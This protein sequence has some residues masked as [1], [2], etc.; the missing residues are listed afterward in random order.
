VIQPEGEHHESIEIHPPPHEL[1]A[2]LLLALLAAPAAAQVDCTITASDAKSYDGSPVTTM[3]DKITVEEGGDWQFTLTYKCTGITDPVTHKPY[4]SISNPSNMPSFDVKD[5]RGG[6][7]E[8]DGFGDG[9]AMT[10][11]CLE[12]SGCRIVWFGSSKD[13]NCNNVGGTL[14]TL[15]VRTQISNTGTGPANLSGERT[16][17]VEAIDDDPAF[18]YP[19]EKLG[20]TTTR[21]P[22]RPPC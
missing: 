18:R 14:Q 12:N 13:N 10:G 9:D 15:N 16:F 21:I 22:W 20:D 2:L 7:S 1:A 3:N 11:A 17:T 6:H 19:F 5:F 8:L 4:I